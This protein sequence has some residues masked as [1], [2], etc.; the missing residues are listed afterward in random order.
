MSPDILSLIYAIFKDFGAG[1]VEFG[2]IVF[3]ICKLGSNH[4]RHIAIDIKGCHEDI[5]ILCKKMD[6]TNT[7]V[8][9]LG[10]RVSKLEGEVQ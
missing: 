8:N 1:A 3:L 7:K 2:V 4:L 9:S 5:K 6:D 10:E